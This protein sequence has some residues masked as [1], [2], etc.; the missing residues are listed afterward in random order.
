MLGLPQGLRGRATDPAKVG[1]LPPVW[2][3]AEPHGAL[4]LLPGLLA[5][6]AHTSTTD[7]RVSDREIQVLA[8]ESRGR[9]R[10]IWKIRGIQVSSRHRPYDC[11]DP[12]PPYCSSRRDKTL[13]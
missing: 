5:N 9:Y 1:P 7:H 13:S 6:A 10:A 2:W 4:C 3:H 8:A 11:P 12:L